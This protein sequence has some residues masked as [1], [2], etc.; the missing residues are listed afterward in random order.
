M[1]RWLGPQ[2][3]GGAGRTDRP[4]GNPGGSPRSWLEQGT[5]SAAGK[6]GDRSP[7]TAGHLG[8]AQKATSGR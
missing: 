4:E 1:P 6:L 7:P 2:V 3:G 8:H 5:D